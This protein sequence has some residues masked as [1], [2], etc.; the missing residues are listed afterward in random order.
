MLTGTVTTDLTMAAAS[1]VSLRS[2]TWSHDVLALCDLDEVMP[3]LPP[4]V[5]SDAIAGSV[6]SDAAGS[7]GLQPE[8]PPGTVGT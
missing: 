1:F 6:T 4:V 5:A 7:T 2:R 3:K 8:T